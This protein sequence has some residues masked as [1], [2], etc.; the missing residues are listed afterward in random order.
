M[1]Q[2]DTDGSG[3]LDRKEIAA[4]ATNLG[5]ALNSKGLDEAMQQMDQ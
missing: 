2:I 5:Q 1:S 4:L 3:T